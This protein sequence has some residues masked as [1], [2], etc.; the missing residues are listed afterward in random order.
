MLFPCLGRASHV[1][2]LRAPCSRL[3][4]SYHVL[5]HPL[6]SLLTFFYQWND[7]QALRIREKKEQSEWAFHNITALLQAYCTICLS[8]YMY[9]QNQSHGNRYIAFHLR[10]IIDISGGIYERK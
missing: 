1:S 5:Y 7:T 3:L 2:L 10:S 8:K 4:R 6:Y 9:P